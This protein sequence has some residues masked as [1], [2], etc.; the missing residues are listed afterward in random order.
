M[1]IGSYRSALYNANANSSQ[2]LG[3][4]QVRGYPVQPSHENVGWALA[5]LQLNP[6]YRLAQSKIVYIK[7]TW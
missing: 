4:G 2:A 5:L 1:N 3:L 6:S 7:G